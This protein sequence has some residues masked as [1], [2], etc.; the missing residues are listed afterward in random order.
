[1]IVYTLLLQY[2]DQNHDELLEINF[3]NLQEGNKSTGLP[4]FK[5]NKPNE[6]LNFLA[7]TLTCFDFGLP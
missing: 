1:L 6:Y 2:F 4:F 5:T 7:R 3:L